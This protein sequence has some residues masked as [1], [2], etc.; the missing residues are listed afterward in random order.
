MYKI[1]TTTEKRFFLGWLKCSVGATH[2]WHPAHGYHGHTSDAHIEKRGFGGINYA[3]KFLN[4]E[5]E[6]AGAPEGNPSVAGV[7]GGPASE[8]SYWFEKI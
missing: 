3:L 1:K 2:E 5:I 8:L 6:I 7:E 4:Q